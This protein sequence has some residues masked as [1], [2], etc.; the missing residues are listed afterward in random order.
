MSYASIY[1]KVVGPNQASEKSNAY[2][3]YKEQY[4][5]LGTDCRKQN[6]STGLNLSICRHLWPTLVFVLCSNHTRSDTITSYTT[7]T[8]YTCTMLRDYFWQFKTKR[9][10]IEYYLNRSGQWCNKTLVHPVIRLI[11][12]ITVSMKHKCYGTKCHRI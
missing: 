3:W 7:P 10:I 6:R 8:I 1:I 4:W 12:I 5:S 11:S 9:T 2:N